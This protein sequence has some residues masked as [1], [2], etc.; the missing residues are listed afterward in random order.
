M[1]PTAFPPLLLLPLWVAAGCL[2]PPRSL[3]WR[4]PELRGSASPA[5][6]E[7]S[8]DDGAALVARE[9]AR[10]GVRFGT[11]GSVG[12]LYS[13]LRSE[14]PALPPAEARPG[15]V[16]FFDS[17]DPKAACGDRAALVERIEADGR[18]TFREGRGGRVRIGHAQPRDP[19][20]RRDE[21]NRVV[22]TF[23]RPKRREDPPGTRYH[24]GALLCAVFRVDERSNDGREKRR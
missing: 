24:A 9:L 17:G 18:M 1:S 23:L 8:R 4:S 6:P 15:D 10:R 21:A 16:L 20:R 12:A 7:P 5:V 14:H 3:V 2:S 19:H 22:N 11:D 13:Y